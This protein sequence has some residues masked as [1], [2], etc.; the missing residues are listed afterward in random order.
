VGDH[1]IRASLA[2]V[3]DALEQQRMTDQ[4][5]ADVYLRVMRAFR[6][7]RDSRKTGQQAKDNS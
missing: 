4:Q 2:E 6:V 5:R 7:V 3:L 1:A